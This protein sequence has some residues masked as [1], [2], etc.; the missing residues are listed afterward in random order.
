QEEGRTVYF[1]KDNGVGFTMAEKDR[2][3]HLFERLHPAT[4]FEGT[5]IGL[6]AVQRAIERHRGRVWATG[7]PGKGATFFFTL[8][9]TASDAARAQAA[10]ATAS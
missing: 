4:D 3:F 2:L 5:G 6:V 7:E 10:E 1:V 8:G 9:G